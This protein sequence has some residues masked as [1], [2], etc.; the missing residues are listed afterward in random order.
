[1]N[2]QKGIMKK[3]QILHVEDNLDEI[4]LV[5]QAVEEAGIDVE[6]SMELDGE[7][8]IQR[9]HQEN[10][11]P[12]SVFPDI[13]LLDLNLPKKNGFEV[14]NSIKTDPQLKKIPVFVFT[15]S[16]SEDDVNRAYQCHANGYIRKPANFSEYIALFGRLAA[17]WQHIIAPSPIKT[18]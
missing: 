1:M 10:F 18:S 12:Q 11:S 2:F 9:L 6:L 7:A 16:E 5:K 14:L 13:V 3:L 17:F 4:R 8:A 15:G